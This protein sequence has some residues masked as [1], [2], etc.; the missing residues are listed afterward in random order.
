MA[1]RVLLPS[2]EPPP[3]DWKLAVDATALG[4][5]AVVRGSVTPR[6]EVTVNGRLVPVG[7]GG[8]FTGT[9][10]FG[11][12]REVEVVAFDGSGRRLI[13]RQTFP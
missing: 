5:A 10:P 9:F 8:E 7:D 4:D 1:F 2:P 12:G 13:W 11:P 3:S 6:L